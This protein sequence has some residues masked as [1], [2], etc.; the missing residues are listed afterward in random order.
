MN[1]QYAKSCIRVYNNSAQD[2]TAALT[3]LNLEGTPVVQSGCSMTLN[4]T[5]IQVN[6]S[7][8]YHLS[9]DVTYTPTAAGVAIIQLYKDEV[10]LPCAI[11]QHTVVAGSVYTD[12]IETDLCLATCCVNRP[13]ITLDISGVAGTVNHTCVGMVKLA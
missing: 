12:H 6:R 13:L 5:S 11:A 1:N 2:F 4:T 3:P 7:G 10:A 8:L 9:A